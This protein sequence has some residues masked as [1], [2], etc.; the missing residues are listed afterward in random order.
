M[1]VAFQI[2]SAGKAFHADKEA[3]FGHVKIAVSPKIACRKLNLV[4]L[5]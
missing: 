1:V 2:E 3:L 5:G 4:I